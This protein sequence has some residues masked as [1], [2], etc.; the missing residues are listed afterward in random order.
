[1]ESPLWIDTHAPAV[2]DLPQTEL[3]AYL[4]RAADGPVN[5]VLHG[6]AGVGKTAAARALAR[7]SLADPENDLVEINVDDFFNR[8]KAEIR[9]DPRFEH[10]LRGQTEFSKQFR[11][12]TERPNKYKREWSKGVM[13]TH[14]LKELAGYR[15]TSGEYK[16]IVLDNAE[17]A[18]LDFQHALRRVMERHHGTT[19][20]VLTT[21][22]PSKLIPALTSRC[23]PIPVR[24]PT[25]AETTAVLE[26]IVEAEG[27]DYEP[28]GLDYVADHAGGDLRAA[29]LDAQTVAVEAGEVTRSAAYE[30]IKEVGLDDR[31]AEMLGHAA[32]GDFGEARSVLDDL[33]FDDGY[34]G[35]DV[36]AAVLR[37]AR[38]REIGEA[39][40]LAALAG[41]I[42]FD[43]A[44]GTNDR[45][46]LSHLLA[47]L[48]AA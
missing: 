16:T 34:T 32:D 6:P 23:L 40:Q 14:V 45:L 11:D 42:D 8:T 12:G 15:P 10:F 29:I 48:G 44:R 21:R 30:V 39:A 22:Q 18:R 25:R 9:E 38:T 35:E 2:A 5:L 19:Q 3:R 27:V 28:S 13:I 1:M 4:E 17:A 43:L 41:R 24:S 36:L 20:F 37:V 31:I 26:R 7:E 46:H 47:E 33:L